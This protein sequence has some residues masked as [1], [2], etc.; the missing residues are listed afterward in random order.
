MMMYKQARALCSLLSL[1]IL[2]AA[3]PLAAGAQTV[4]AADVEMA[5]AVIQ[6]NTMTLPGLNPGSTFQISA[7][8]FSA[9]DAL[10]IYLL[11]FHQKNQVCP[12]I[13]AVSEAL[14]KLKDAEVHKKAVAMF[15]KD[16]SSSSDV[17]SGLE[18]PNF[19]RDTFEWYILTKQTE[20]QKIANARLA[21]YVGADEAWHR[22]MESQ[23]A[24]WEKSTSRES[25]FILKRGAYRVSLDAEAAVAEADRVVSG[26]Q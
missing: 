3:M 6:K 26:G 14:K 23:R 16:Y 12:P 10:V 13:E 17:G 19:L 4:T 22:A 18:K 20:R 5:K 7:G 21:G 8:S 9:A 2:F 11:K 1:A 24:S 25:E 15:W